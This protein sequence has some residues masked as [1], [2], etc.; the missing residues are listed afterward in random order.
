MHWLEMLQQR[1]ACQSIAAD[2]TGV[3]SSRVHC[4]AAQRGSL[5]IAA[6]RGY[7]HCARSTAPPRRRCWRR[8]RAYCAVRRPRSRARTCRPCCPGCWR[9]SPPQGDPGGLMPARGTGATEGMLAGAWRRTKQRLTRCWPRWARRCRT[10]A[11]WLCC[12]SAQ[13]ETW[14]GCSAGKFA[15]FIAH[16]WYFKQKCSGDTKPTLCYSWKLHLRT[17]R[18][19]HPCMYAIPKEVSLGC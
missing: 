1:A 9:G 13:S 10:P 3:V 8:W 12:S 7:R 18:H 15:Y 5:L 17:Q 11:V 14:L 16:L 6:R 19:E 2:A 4:L